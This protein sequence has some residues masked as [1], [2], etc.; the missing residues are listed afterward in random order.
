MALESAAHISEFVATNPT[1]TD[2]KSQGDD[3]IRL[4]KGAVKNDFSGFGGF[5][6][7]MGSESQGS[8][9]N[10]YVVTVSGVDAY[11]DGMVVIFTASHTNSAA[12]TLG[13]NALT[14]SPLVC[15]DGTALVGS[16]VASGSVVMAA[17]SLASGHFKMI[18]ANGALYAP[19]PPAGDSS[20]RIATTDFVN[21]VAFS[22]ALPGQGDSSG[23]FVSTDG[24]V[25][26]W[27]KTSGT[28]YFLTA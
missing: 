3:H 8:T 19:T 28:I 11:T 6:L 7:V 27:K 18:S 14:P 22:A 24:A 16:S 20:M 4:V 26:S 10:D 15:V 25:A 23:S 13:I 17:Y 1:S 12:A 9:E 21:Q 5:V 2:P